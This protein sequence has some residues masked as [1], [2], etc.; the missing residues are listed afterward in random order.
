MDS[1]DFSEEEIQEQLVLLGYRNIPKHRLREF[2]K[3]GKRPSSFIPPLTSFYF[4]VSIN[5]VGHFHV[6]K[7]PKGSPFVH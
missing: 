7:C 5:I 3:G 1:L 6:S 2:K 4:V